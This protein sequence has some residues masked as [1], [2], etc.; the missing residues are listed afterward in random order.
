MKHI[1]VCVRLYSILQYVRN[2]FALVF[3]TE[4]FR[5]VYQFRNAFKLAIVIYLQWGRA[6]PREINTNFPEDCG[7]YRQPGA[8][9]THDPKN[10]GTGRSM[11]G[12]WA[13]LGR[14]GWRLLSTACP[15]G[16]ASSAC[17]TAAVSVS[18]GLGLGWGVTFK[19]RFRFEVNVNV[20]FGAC[21]QVRV[22]VRV[23]ARVR[24]RVR[25]GVQVWAGARAEYMAWY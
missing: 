11:P 13:P 25:F 22:G 19:F 9:N 20:Q 10:K 7:A 4:F 16:G 2:S 5:C 12:I 8:L 1:C 14:D 21:I 6:G 3:K 23:G 17:R 15:S 24:V 18:D